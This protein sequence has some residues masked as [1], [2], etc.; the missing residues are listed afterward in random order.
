MEFLI[1]KIAFDSE[2]IELVSGPRYLEENP[3]NQTVT[4][5]YSSWGYRGYSEVWLEGANDWIYRHLHEA[6]KR[7]HEMAKEHHDAQGLLRRALNQTARELLLAEA[8]DWAFM[9]KSGTS[10]EY[11]AKRT[12]EHLLAFLRLEDEIHRNTID[13]PKL[14][15]LETKDCIF[16]QINFEVYA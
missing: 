15:E 16:P 5:C 12:R 9:M 4:P 2:V 10:V 13:E 6:S 7:M 3:K 11:A 8:S 14:R 1:R